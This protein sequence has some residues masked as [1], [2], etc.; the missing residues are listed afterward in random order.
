MKKIFQNSRILVLLTFAAVVVLLGGVGKTVAYYQD[1]SNK[2]VNEF[3]VGNV[4]TEIV[5]IF[6]K[7]N[8]HEY[9]KEPRVTNTGMNDCYVRIRWEVTPEN[10]MKDRLEFVGLAGSGWEKDGDWYYY[11]KAI[12]PGESTTELFKT[13]KVAYNET[14][15][16]WVDFDIILYQEAVQ[17]VVNVDGKV[18]TDYQTIWTQY[19]AK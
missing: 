6:N 4:T 17:A 3:T 19:D 14:D 2:E 10:I 1:Q 7:I 11:T 15:M 13:V 12:K 5:E 16:P 18:I 9:Q 8:D